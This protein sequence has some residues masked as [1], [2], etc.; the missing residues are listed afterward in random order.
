MSIDLPISKSIANRLLILQALDDKPLMDVSDPNIPQD[1]KVLHDALTDIAVGK[2]RLD[3]GEC[4]TAMRFLTAYCAR[5]EGCNVRLDGTPRMRKRPIEKLVR[6]L[7][8]CGADIW[9]EGEMGFV[10]LRIHGRNL[11]EPLSGK[12]FQPTPRIKV[13]SPDSSQF[14]SALLLVG[15]KAE[16]NLNSPYIRMTRTIIERWR[17]GQQITMERDW[18]SAA[19]WYEYVA[20]HG[21][22]LRLNGLTEDTVQGDKELIRLFRPFGVTTRFDAEGA[23]IARTQRCS[24][25]PR[26]VNFRDFPD[27]Y[28][29]YAMTCK[30]LHIPLLALG[31]DSLRLKES[32]RLKSV[33]ERQS[34]GDHRVAMALMA[35]DLPCDDTQCIAKS[36]PAFLENLQRIHDAR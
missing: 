29:A 22:E 20:I 28:P 10:P 18:S 33:K 25:L 3:L 21:G 31:T 26:I 23:V 13:D 1:V 34:Y 27:I 24:H 7:I 17:S 5:K 32:D 4:G 9:Y 6:A 14:V 12:E 36:Y 30:R 35:A 15:L 2:Q 16:T 11:V 19:F 8:A